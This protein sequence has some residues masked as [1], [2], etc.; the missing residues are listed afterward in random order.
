MPDTSKIISRLTNPGT[1]ILLVGAVAVYA[2]AFIAR[3]LSHDE[4]K[5][6]TLSIAIKAAGCLFALLGMLMLFDYIG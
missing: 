4:A 5:Q 1:I 6:N 3:K 2:S